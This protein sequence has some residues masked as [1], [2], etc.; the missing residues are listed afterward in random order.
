VLVAYSFSGLE[1]IFP[2]KDKLVFSY[3]VVQGTTQTKSGQIEVVNTDVPLKNI[4]KS[5]K[6]FTWF[7][8][9]QYE[10]NLKKLCKFSIEKLENEL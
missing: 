2:E 1:A 5:T 3:K 7:Y 4:W 6:K 9:D 10:N 8:I